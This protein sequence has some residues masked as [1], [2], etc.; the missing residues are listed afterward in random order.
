MLVHKLTTILKIGLIGLPLSVF[1]LPL[2]LTYLPS[3]TSLSLTAG[4]IDV[5]RLLEPAVEPQE[6]GVDDK[7][8]QLPQDII[9]WHS[10]A[11]QLGEEVARLSQQFNESQMAYR[12]R[13]V[14]KGDYME[15]LTSFAA[16][17]RAKHPPNL[18]QVFEVGTSVMRS[19]R[20][21]IKPVETLMREQGVEFPKGQYFPAVLSHYSM[22]GV[23]LAMPFNVSIPVMFYNADALA[24]L[25]VTQETFPKSWQGFERLAERLHREG[26]SC[27]YTSAYPAWILIESYQ[28]LHGLNPA[29]GASKDMI[30]QQL[31]SHLKR[32]QEWQKK[33]YFEYGGRGDDPTALFTSGKCPIFSQSSGAFE[34]LSGLTSFHLGVAPIPFDETNK[35][36]RHNNIVGGAALWI[37]AGQSK[38]IEHGIS[39]YLAFIAKPSVQRSWYE[40]TGYLPMDTA[41][42]ASEHSILDI[43]KLDLNHQYQAVPESQ[44]GAENQIRTIYDQMLEAIF[45][46]MMSVEDAMNKADRRIQH[47]LKRFRRN[48]G[49]A[50]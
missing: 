49:N 44:Q 20:G 35:S 33:H 22:D 18:V 23:L 26:F 28:A 29:E 5:A 21:V 24:K 39:L 10:M 19:P 16:A 9:F 25:G 4:S 6:V 14:Y 3:P 7:G 48:N 37:P 1:A 45:S 47:V 32:M 17:F 38:E 30:H 43:A 40:H 46:G 41:F 12:V 8:E 42:Q 50:H 27:A 34:A 11:G 31:K 13:P 36:T 2:K 15:S